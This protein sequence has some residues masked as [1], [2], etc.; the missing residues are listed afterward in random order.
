MSRPY[1][2]TEGHRGKRRACAE[3]VVAN[4]I[5]SDPHL[6]TF[7]RQLLHRI[8]LADET[9][10]RITGGRMGLVE[11]A[12]GHE[13]FGMHRRENGWVFREWA[14]NATAIYL[15]GPF[16]GWKTEDRFALSRSGQSGDWEIELPSETL[17]HG[18]TYRLEMH[19][20]EGSGDRIPAWTRRVVQ[21]P[22]TSS[23]NAQIWGPENPYKWRHTTPKRDGS[24]FLAY[25]THIGMAT[26]EE[27]TGTFD[28][29]RKEVLPRIRDAGYGAIQIM[30]LAE[31]PYYA[32]FGYQVS[33]FFACSSRFGTPEEL[34]ALVDTAHGMGLVVL[35]DLVHSHAV[36]NEVEGIS[37]FDGTSHQFFHEGERGNHPAWDSKCFDYA[38]PEV[39]HFLLSNCRYWMDEF[40]FDGFRFDGVT[41]MLYTHHGLGKAFTGYTDYFDASV[42]EDALAYLT[43]ANRL[44]H[45]L[46]SRAVTVAEDVSGMPGLAVSDDQ[47]GAGFDYRYAMG[48]P[49]Y[50]IRL[51]KDTPDDLWPMGHLWHELTNRR[52][53]EKT[54]SYAESHDQ[55]MVGDQTLIF[56]LLGDRIYGYMS[57]STDDVV[58]SRGIALHKMIRLATLATAGHGYLNFMGNEF[59]HPEWI[60]FPREGNKWSYRYARRQWHLADDPDLR[61][62]H[63]GAFDRD[64]IRMARAKKIPGGEA[65]YLLHADEE[66]KVLAFL[67]GTTVFVFNFHPRRSFEHYRIPAAPGR[68][69]IILDADAGV[70]GGFN[71][72]DASVVHETAT[73]RIH[74][75]HLSL[76]LPSRTA[77]VLELRNGTSNTGGPHP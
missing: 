37:R 74:R 19:W 60:D 46:S 59:G 13:H 16:S 22:A 6:E 57:V 68:Y 10:R 5:E 34:K 3:E 58:V 51:V 23:F 73:D 42:D 64:M 36:K 55:A 54:I 48:V 44:I 12:S 50:W 70:Y 62:A 11:F 72:R 66:D 41:S 40:R 69:R 32:S 49:D 63:L 45:S 26:T 77:L 8:Q 35:M 29:F 15:K 76:Y 53:D 18:D 24:P 25:E 27:R 67:R 61:Y 71:R 31:H 9:E 75:H 7:E 56:R 17:N 30:A 2:N 39:L 4:R 14:P 47:G 21:D 1:E 52:H 28:E 38:K 65:A 43:L 20:R 33:S